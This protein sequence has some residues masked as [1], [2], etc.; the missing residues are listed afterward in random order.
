VIT[1]EHFPIEIRIFVA[2]MASRRGVMTSADPD[3]RRSIGGP[4]DRTSL[5]HGPAAAFARQAFD[6]AQALACPTPARGEYLS[7]LGD[8]A[9]GEFLAHAAELAV[10]GAPLRQMVIFRIGQG[11]AAVPG[12]T[13]AFSH[14]DARYLFHPISIWSDPADDERMIAANR[15]FTAAMRSYG[16]GATY[17]NFTPEADRVRDAYATPCTPAWSR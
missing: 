11:I 14:C 17:L 8:A 6:T 7:A 12:G 9:I 2:S 13:T 3:V 5:W 4:S 10:A 16:T 15:A 1:C